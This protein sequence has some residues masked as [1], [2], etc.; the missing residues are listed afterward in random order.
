MIGAVVGIL[1]IC[2]GERMVQQAALWAL[3]C[4]CSRSMDVPT[5]TLQ[6]SMEG[7]AQC[8]SLAV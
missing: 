7:T 6:G 2:I 3:Y 4:P 5:R 1:L 8:S